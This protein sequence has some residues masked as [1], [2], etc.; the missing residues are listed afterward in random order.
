MVRPSWSQR[1]FIPL[2]LVLFSQWLVVS[3]LDGWFF[4]AYPCWT[5]FLKIWYLNLYHP[6]V[7]FHWLMLL[8]LPK[9][10]NFPCQ[11]THIAKENSST[12]DTSSWRGPLSSTILQVD[13]RIVIS[14][15]KIQPLIQVTAPSVTPP[16]RPVPWCIAASMALEPT[17]H[18][19][20]MSMWY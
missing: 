7:V 1:V 4:C 11:Q 20:Y 6:V 9:K 15:W 16:P 17:I 2:F 5:R 14:P 12:K 18:V 10:L 19:Y 8:V 3:R 13:S